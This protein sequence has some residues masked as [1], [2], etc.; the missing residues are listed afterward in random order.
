MSPSPI[1]GPQMLQLPYGPQSL[2]GAHMLTFVA[3]Y[4]TYP[5]EGLS[6]LNSILWLS[7]LITS[8]E[9]NDVLIR[10]YI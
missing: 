2:Y 10:L 9:R 4:G 7:G 6:Q 8:L 3:K 5:W 1:F